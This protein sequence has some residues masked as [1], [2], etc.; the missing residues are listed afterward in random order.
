MIFSYFANSNAINSEMA[1][2]LSGS[3]LYY[4]RNLVIFHIGATDLEELCTSVHD[5]IKR[6]LRVLTPAF[7][8]LM[9][10]P[11]SPCL[12]FNSVPVTSHTMRSNRLSKLIKK[13]NEEFDI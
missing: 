6:Q 2:K 12:T 10:Y 9:S 3:L 5:W 8:S 7:T 4:A 1:T 11:E 13:V